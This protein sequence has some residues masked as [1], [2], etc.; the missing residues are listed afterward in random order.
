MSK[1]NFQDWIEEKHPQFSS[2]T[3]A[4]I[5]I[6]T[7]LLKDEGIP[8]LTIAGRTKS[9]AD[10]LNKSR[11]KSYKNPTQQMTDISG[12][13]IV[14]YFDYD[15]D[16][17]SDIIEQ[18]FA[19]DENNSSNRDDLLLVNEVGYRSMHFVCDLGEDRVRLKENEL[20]RGLKFEF[21]VRTV[22]QHAWAELAHDRNYKFTGQL[23]KP[24]E[25]KLFLLAGLMETADNG[26]SELSKEID[27]YV[28]SISTSAAKGRLD[29]IIADVRNPR[30]APNHSQPAS[31]T[32]PRAF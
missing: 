12:V 21:Q 16:R 25:R 30:Q 3:E 7:R 15:V 31:R 1:L 18:N 24:I 10:C 9:V 4:V 20:L 26:F 23:P 6:I 13:R 2:L 29:I 32:T 22:L 19:V 8:F 11:R 5:L 17:V 27:S 14:V 28:D